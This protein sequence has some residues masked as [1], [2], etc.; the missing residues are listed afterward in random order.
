MRVVVTGGGGY[1]G[2]WV[3]ALLLENGHSVRN[4]DRFCFGQEPIQEFVDNP[5]YESIVGDI[6]N[7]GDYPNLLKDVDAV[8]HLAGLANDPSCDLDPEMTLDVNIDASLELLNISLRA[9]VRRFAFASS[10]SVYGQGFMN[11]SM[12]KV[13]PIRSP[14]MP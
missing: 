4:F 8:V 12:K 11:S 2:T 6:R 7:L 1:L 5:N 14:R 10:C 3:T 9:G 13:Q